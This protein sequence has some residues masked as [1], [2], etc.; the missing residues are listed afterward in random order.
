MGEQNL[1][2]IPRLAELLG[3]AISTIHYY[4]ANGLGPR[5]VKLGR[6]VRYRISDV[7]EWLEALENQGK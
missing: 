4:R 3:V 6:L 2:T 5:A 1:I 7:Q